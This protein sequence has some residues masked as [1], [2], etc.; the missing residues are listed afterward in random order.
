M[1]EIKIAGFRKTSLVD[2]TD[3]ISTVLFTQGCNCR[4][5]YCHNPGLIPKEPEDQDYMDLDYFWNFLEKRQHLLDGV[6][7]TGGEPTLQEGIFDFIQNIKNRGLKVKLDTNGANFQI[8]Q[9]LIKRNYI[10]YCAVDF[11]ASYQN[12]EQLTGKNITKSLK[13]CVNLV[14]NDDLDYEFRTTVVPGIHTEVEIKKIA[15]TIK[16]A[17]KYCIQNFRPKITLDSDFENKRQFPEEKLEKFKKIAGKFV[18]NVE[19]R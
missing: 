19:I 17:E 3:H 9:K 18:K 13:K 6:V 10:D 12:Y 5:P 7:I 2:Y 15:E 4:C 1:K 8:L 14:V 16:G 11:K